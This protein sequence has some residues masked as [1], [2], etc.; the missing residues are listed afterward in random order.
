MV[1]THPGKPGTIG[2]PQVSERNL[3]TGLQI[4]G[5]AA[6]HIQH[7]LLH[8]RSAVVF[9]SRVANSPY[10]LQN[11][12][13]DYAPMQRKHEHYLEAAH[14]HCRSL[15]PRTMATAGPARIQH[16]RARKLQPFSADQ[17]HAVF[18]WLLFSLV[19]PWLL[20][21]SYVLLVA[22]APWCARAAAIPI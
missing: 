20:M 17:P 19:S 13:L 4:V 8:K 7:F 18:P 10:F 12:S 6:R 11:N 9:S 15:D 5:Q 16:P 22:D 21:F 2:S 3:C 14:L 1:Q